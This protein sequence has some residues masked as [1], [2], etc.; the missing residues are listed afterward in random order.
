MMAAKSKDQ[1]VQ[2]LTDRGIK[3]KKDDDKKTLRE[4]LWANRDKPNL[5]MRVK[6]LGCGH[7]FHFHC[8]RTWMGSRNTCPNCRWKLEVVQK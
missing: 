5:R 6:K 8:L 2:A 4:K 7:M 3:F 1:L